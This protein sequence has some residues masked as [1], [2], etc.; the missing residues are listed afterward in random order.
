MALTG[1]FIITGAASGIGAAVAKKIAGPNCSLI[2][3]TRSN[4]DDLERLAD[5]C[6]AKG[7]LVYT[8]K[9]DLIEQSQTQKLINFS[10][11]KF[12]S[13]DGVIAAAGYPDWQNFDDLSVEDFMKSVLLMQQS[14]FMLLQQFNRQLQTS[15]GSFVAV[16]S[17]LAHKMKVGNSITP[18]SASAK[19]GLEALVKSYAAQYAASGIRCNAIVPGY[20]KKD[21]GKHTPISPD[22][23]AKINA[24]IPAGRLGL[25][26]EVA[27]LAQFLLSSQSRYITG[28]LLHIDGG[29]LL[30]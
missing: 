8:Q 21:G 3:Q 4:L 15:K 28:Q 19:A 14:T 30:T 10:L 2:L 5:I 18:A 27:S 13:I 9:I 12:S 6:K 16:S 11:D 24:R 7:A 23:I 17:F 26:E 29:L 20:I 22:A 1:N 25:P